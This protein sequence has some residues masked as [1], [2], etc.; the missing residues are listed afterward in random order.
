[1]HMDELVALE[2]DCFRLGADITF[3]RSGKQ[4]S[5][6]FQWN[7]FEGDTFEYLYEYCACRG[8]F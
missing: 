6:T 8:R 7:I 1:M 5:V 4:A 3:L 2:K